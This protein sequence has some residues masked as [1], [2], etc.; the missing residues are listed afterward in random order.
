DLFAGIDEKDLLELVPLCHFEIIEKNTVV[1]PAGSYGDD[2][3]FLTGKNDAIQIELPVE[4]FER[5][6][7]TN[8]L[9]KGQLFGWCSLVPQQ[10]RTT[11]ARCIDDT[12][13]ITIKG[14]DL[15]NLLDKNN[16]M[17]YKIM[18]NFSSILCSR[19]TYTSVSLRHLVRQLMKSEQNWKI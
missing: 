13:V 14:N 4:G 2:I 8:V 17:G 10:L 18:R 19:L 1:H 12:E 11:Q 9:S 16:R 15:L 7:V 5:N 3:Y 6:V